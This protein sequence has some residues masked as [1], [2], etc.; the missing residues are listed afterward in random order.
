MAKI[1]KNKNIKNKKMN[2]L[3]LSKITEVDMPIGK[4]YSV[5]KQYPQYTGLGRGAIRVVHRE[6]LT[7]IQGNSNTSTGTFVIGLIYPMQ[8]GSDVT[9]QWLYQLAVLFETYRINKM[10][11]C[12][13]PMCATSQVGSVYLGIDYDPVDSQ[14]ISKS[15]F[16]SLPS[17]ASGPAWQGFC[18]DFDPRNVRPFNEH[19]TRDGIVSGTDLKTYDCGN[20]FIGLDG[21]ANSNQVGDLYVEYD[22][23]FY[24]PQVPAQGAA[25]VS[26]E[27]SCADSGSGIITPGGF[28]SSSGDFICQALSSS[29][30]GQGLLKFLEYGDYIV[31]LYLEG[32]ATNT[33]ATCSGFTN[34]S[35]A[36]YVP[37]VGTAKGMFD[38]IVRVDDLTRTLTIA[39]STLSAITIN[40][41]RISKYYYPLG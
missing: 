1:N 28:T 32:T 38:F 5:P 20:L 3:S 8:P 36:D 7:Q 25:N 27:A 29:T 2:K 41:F 33:V 39:L 30:P 15:A 13:V 9:F 14:P 24:Q 19:Y 31:S 40:R 6:L 4:F 37:L 23:D 21:F 11:F 22:I 12:Y 16:C 34:C 10:R 26:Q 18:L 35:V 17:V